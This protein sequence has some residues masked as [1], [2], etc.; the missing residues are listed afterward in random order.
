[1]TACLRGGPLCPGDAL[2]PVR[3]AAGSADYSRQP[4]TSRCLRLGSR[5]E[6]RTV[7]NPFGIGNFRFRCTKLEREAYFGP[8]HTPI[9]PTP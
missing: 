2:C 7:E 1:M 8:T 9:A 3:D 5:R 6:R 4:L